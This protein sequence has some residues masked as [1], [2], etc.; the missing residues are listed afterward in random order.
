[1]SLSA[2]FI[3]VTSLPNDGY[4][5]F[6]LL[7]LGGVYAYVLC[8]SSSMISDGSE[9]LLLIPSL[10]GLVGSVVL[11][12]LGAV[13][14]GCIVLFSGLG[15]DAQTQ[16]NVGIGAL[17]GS[18]IMLLTA[19]WFLSVLGGRVN[20]NNGVA[21][22]RAPKLEPAGRFDWFNTGVNLS[23]AVNTGGL[24]MLVTSIPF[25][26]IE[27]PAVYFQSYTDAVIGK[28]EL[29]YAFIGMCLCGVMFCGYLYYCYL[30]SNDDLQKARQLEAVIEKIQKGE[31]SLRSIIAAEL[32][33][34]PASGE[35][36][37]LLNSELKSRVE[38]I[39]KPFFKRYDTEEPFNCIT[40]HELLNVFKDLGENP[41]P[42]EF[43]SIF[44]DIDKDSSGDISFSE[45]SEG[46]TKY[47]LNLAQRNASKFVPSGSAKGRRDSAVSNKKDIE[48]FIMSTKEEEEEEEAEMPDDFKDLS[49]MDQQNAVFWRSMITMGL[50]TLIVVI[51]S[52]PMV[53]VLNEIGVRTNI[54]PFYVSFVL[55]PLASNASE[56]IASYNYSQK[57]T[58]KSIEIALSALQGACCMNNTFVLGIF[59]I[60]VYCQGLAWEFFAETVTI[61]VSVFFI[62]VM[63]LKKSHSMFDAL[64]ICCVYPASLILVYTLEAHGWN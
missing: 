18:T 5:M 22:Y 2:L 46:I 27:I 40:K 59:F 60:C 36:S 55:A 31:I 19:P 24:L 4:G 42:R 12:V 39:V 41:N 47:V 10:A 43:E 49:P 3:D 57:K 37:K 30:V 17:A 29:P 64:L 6:Q 23:T 53:D 51:F 25:F 52:D 7:F 38:A 50:G 33:N 48:M 15:P 11:P 32:Q 45:F 54:P 13:P 8:Y 44:T 56:V 61:L 14:D 9:L 21:S 16:L 1:M 62:A 63:S 28:D 35:G 20:M 26:I 58:A 34:N